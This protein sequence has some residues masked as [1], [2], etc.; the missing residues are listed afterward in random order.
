MSVCY[1][2]SC[3]DLTKKYSGFGKMTNFILPYILKNLVMNLFRIAG[4]RTCGHDDFG[5]DE[6]R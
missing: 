3:I 6:D 2:P 5:T 1:W 4:T